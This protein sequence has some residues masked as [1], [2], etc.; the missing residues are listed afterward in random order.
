MPISEKIFKAYDIRGLSEEIT[1]EVA[2]ATARVLVRKLQ[3]K[4]IIV[5]RDARQTSPQLLQAAVRGIQAEGA[6]AIVIGECSTSVFNYAVTK[7][8]LADGGLMV[9]ASHNPAAYNGL[10]CSDSTGLPLSGQDLMAE[11]IALSAEPLPVELAGGLEEHDVLD[12]YVAACL[13]GQPI[14]AF[15]GLK[16]AVDYGNGMGARAFQAVAAALGL[17]LHELYETPDP[18]FPNHEANPAKRETLAD[19]TALVLRVGACCGIA[20]DG[21]ADRVGFVDERGQPYRGDHILGLLAVGVLK[22]QPGAKIIIQPN[23]SWATLDAI[24]AHGGQMIMKPVGRTHVIRGMHAEGAVLGGEVADH[25][26]FAEF[27]GLE[28]VDFAAVEVLKKI[29]LTHQPLSALLAP[30]SQYHSSW[31]LNFHVDQPADIVARLASIYIPQATTVSQL[32]GL[33][34]DFA[35]DWWFIVRPSSTEPIL[36]LTIEAKSADLLAL[37]MAELQAHL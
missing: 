1:P 24:Q 16:V 12:D 26:F 4:R 10:K 36:R 17:E 3:A 20:F 18:N 35:R 31:D 33:R 8:G 22:D 28:A 29:A 2:I 25:F 32:D 13:A 19:L 9:T 6:T 14:A 37:K 15:Q 11:V 30:Y 23:H 21:D 7:A 27:A 34:C 5:G